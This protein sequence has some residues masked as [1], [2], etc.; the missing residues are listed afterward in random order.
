MKRGRWPMI[1]ISILLFSFLFGVWLRSKIDVV[2]E[3]IPQK[4]PTK[5]II[6]I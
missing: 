1:L 6:S 5:A 4:E 3:P 2:Q